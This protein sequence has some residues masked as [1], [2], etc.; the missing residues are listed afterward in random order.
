VTTVWGTSA[1]KSADRFTYVP[2]PVLT[3]LSPSRGPVLGGT[4]VTITG[5]DLLAPTAVHFGA[6]AARVVR[7]LSA[8]NIAVSSPKGTGTVAVTVTTAGGASAKTAADRFTY[9]PT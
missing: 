3:Q 2:R 9:V 4:I 6:K 1:N 8:V 5:K 7:V